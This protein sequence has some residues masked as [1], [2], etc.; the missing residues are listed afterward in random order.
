MK[1]DPVWTEKM[2]MAYLEEAAAI[3]RRLPPVKVQGYMNLWPETLKSDW[4]RFYD[5]ANTRTRPGPVMP[6]EVT[7]HELIM[8]WLRWLDPYSQKIV[9][10]RANRI[11]WK[12]IEGELDRHRATLWRDTTQALCQIAGRLNGQKAKP[13]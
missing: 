13:P 4:E 5:A 12:V 11:P 9:W 8:A 6:H 10:M 1:N 7:Y 3:H 2:V